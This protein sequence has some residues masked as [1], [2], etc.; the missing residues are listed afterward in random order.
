MTAK[1][2]MWVEFFLSEWVR[3][4][5]EHEIIQNLKK[6]MEID[7]VKSYG[8]MKLDGFYKKLL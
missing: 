4:D 7:E 1:Q 8:H 3:L 2:K 6:A 5:F